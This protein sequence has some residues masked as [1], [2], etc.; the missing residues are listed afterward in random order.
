VNAGYFARHRIVVGNTL[1][2][3]DLPSPGTR[4]P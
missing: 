2:L 1:V 3:S 4:K